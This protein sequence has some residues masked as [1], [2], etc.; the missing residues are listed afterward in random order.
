MGLI[1]DFKKQVKVKVTKNENDARVL[2]CGEAMQT[3]DD[4]KEFFIIP[5]HQAEYIKTTCPGWDVSD[6]FVPE[7]KAE[8]K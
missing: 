6:E 3:G 7:V 1:D 5:A 8:K 4:G 2:L